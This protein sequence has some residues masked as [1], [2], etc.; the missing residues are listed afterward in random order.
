MYLFLNKLT[1]DG[2]RVALLSDVSEWQ[3]EIFRE[4]GL[5]QGFSP[6]MLS[7]EMGT[8]KPRQEAYLNMLENLKIEAEKCIFVDD[9]PANIEAARAIGIRGIVYTSFEET[10]YALEEELART[11][12]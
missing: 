9:R 12:D 6:I 8:R 11:F 5:Y 10:K 3:A 2:Y 7:Y 1:G 4:Q